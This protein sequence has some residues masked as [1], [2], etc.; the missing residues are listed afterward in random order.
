MVSY[1]PDYDLLERLLRDTNSNFI[2]YIDGHLSDDAVF[3]TF[4]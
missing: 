4:L 2:D 3:K 1:P